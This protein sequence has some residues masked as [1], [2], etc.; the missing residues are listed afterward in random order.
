M[1]I[2]SLQETADYLEFAK[3]TQTISLGHAIV[4]KGISAAGVDF[5]LVNDMFGETVL[6][7]YR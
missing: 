4:H 6:T 2:M 3:I 5:V 1:K 7:E